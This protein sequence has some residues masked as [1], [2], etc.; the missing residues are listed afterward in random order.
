M[1]ATVQCRDFIGLTVLM[2]EVC[3]EMD[4]LYL[5]SLNKSKRNS[6]LKVLGQQEDWKLSSFRVW[7]LKLILNLEDNRREHNL[8]T[9]ILLGEA[10]KYRNSYRH[11]E[12]VCGRDVA[13]VHME[14]N[15][16]RGSCRD[17]SRDSPPSAIKLVRGG[18]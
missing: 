4:C 16:I 3:F 14:G 13:D 2:A 8:E 15:I 18:F 11:F 9:G 17:P 10:E 6:Q 7:V 1:G 5:E 12:E